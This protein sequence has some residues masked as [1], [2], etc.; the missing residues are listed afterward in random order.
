MTDKEI[1][2]EMEK[3]S[4]HSITIQSYKGDMSPGR[5]PLQHKIHDNL[6]WLEQRVDEV[7]NYGRKSS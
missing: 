2:R 6:E 5:R 7:I 4:I 3:N 1:M